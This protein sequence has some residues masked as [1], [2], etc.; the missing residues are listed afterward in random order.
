MKNYVFR[1][2]EQITYEQEFLVPA[3]SKEEAEEKL[4]EQTDQADG[5]WQNK[6]T[7]C[8]KNKIQEREILDESVNCL[9]EDS[10]EINPIKG[11]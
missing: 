3:D 4:N 8:L 7:Y 6:H 11:D 9:T 10:E 2:T 1:R 5:E